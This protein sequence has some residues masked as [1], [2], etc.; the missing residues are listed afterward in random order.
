MT[1]LIERARTWIADDPD[2]ATRAAL[3]ELIAR[4]E[5]AELRSRMD[6]VLEFG[7]AGL[8]GEVGAGP[9]RMNRAVVIRTTFGLATFLLAEAGDRPPGPV[10]LG[11]DA[12]PSSRRFAA[13]TAGV[14]TAAGIPVFFFPE[15][16]PTPLVAFAAKHLHAQAAVVVTASHNPPADNG[17]K[18]YDRR[19]SQIVPPMDVAIQEAIDA[20]PGAADI[21]RE[22]SPFEGGTSLAAPVPEDILDCY[23]EEVSSIRSRGAGSDLRV[24]YTP[25]HGVGK[26]ALFEVMGRAGHSSLMAVEEQAEPDGTF[27]TVSFPNPEE[28]GALDLALDM[29]ARESA[30]LVIA[31]DPDAD[32]LAVVI[33]GSDGWRP[34]SGNEVGV[35][36]GDYLLRN[37]ADP[38]SAIVVSSIVSSPMLSHVAVARGARHET[39][40]TGFKWIVKAGLD[41]EAETGGRFLFGYEEALG[42][43][44]GT[45]VHDK[46]GISAALFFLDLTADLADEGH[47]IRHRLHELWSEHGL[48]VSGQTSI[49]RPGR[50]GLEELRNAVDRLGDDPPE[51]LGDHRVTDVIDYR[52]GAS[53]RPSWLGEQALIEMTLGESGRVLVR[54]SGTEPKLKIYVDLRDDP[55]DD[56]D[57]RHAVLEERVAELGQAV[58][59][60]LE[61]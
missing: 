46:D 48:W 53:G 58:A 55:G 7:T 28:P 25:M 19:A 11:Y 57:T 60:Y 33:P 21:P 47:D 12:R 45:T 15:V 24:V 30:D 36:L 22:E 51:S 1:D 18:V 27:P 31:N 34:L 59:R 2:P 44:V 6:T 52:Q 50:D 16:T 4:N 43:T 38:S 35:L 40:L 42:Y 9:G 37:D 39:T 17:Y 8:R 49:T 41:L 61:V 5:T 20:A 10:V 56:P 29:A 26:A 54:P 14:L 13:D 32:R 23:W 3:E